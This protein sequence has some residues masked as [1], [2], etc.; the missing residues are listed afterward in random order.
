M[1]QALN[2]F[3]S[4]TYSETETARDQLHDNKHSRKD[5]HS[6]TKDNV[7]TQRETA[8][9]WSVLISTVYWVSIYYESFILTRYQV[10]CFYQES[11]LTKDVY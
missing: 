5:W 1:Q 10:A 9:S 4:Q 2:C 6:T 8:F 11:Y 7:E 3:T